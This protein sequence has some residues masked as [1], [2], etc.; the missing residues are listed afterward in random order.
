MV[1]GFS[2][3]KQ[4]DWTLWCPKYTEFEQTKLVG[5]YN[6][7]EKNTGQIGSSPEVGVW[8]QI[9]FFMTKMNQSSTRKLERTTGIST[10]MAKTIIDFTIS[11]L[12]K[13]TWDI[14]SP[15]A[16]SSVSTLKNQPG[17]SPTKNH[18][19]AGDRTKITKSK[20]KN[21]MN[22]STSMTL[23]FHVFNFSR[24]LSAIPSRERGKH[25]PPKGKRKSLDSKSAF[26]DMWS[27]PRR[28]FF[29]PHIT[30]FFVFHPQ[31]IP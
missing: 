1:Q 20:R 23:G 25:I 7:F 17:F 18:W 30:L 2:S 6:Q 26:W 11:C 5:G 22:Q 27:F 24:V 10:N 31:Q 28:V 8:N 15:W 12:N 9:M 4:Y 19:M 14:E 13:K 21:H 29:Y 16:T 3:I